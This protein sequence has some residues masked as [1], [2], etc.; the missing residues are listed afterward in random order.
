MIDHRVV[1]FAWS[2]PLVYKLRQGHTQLPLR[3]VLYRYVI[4]ELIERP[5]L[6]F[7]LPIDHSLIG[8][9]H[10]WVETIISQS[11]LR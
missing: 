8:P 11:R 10:E 4:R 3:Q 9:L 5:K 1:E 7:G 2:L 6:G